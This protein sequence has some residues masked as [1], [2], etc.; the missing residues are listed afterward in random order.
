[1]KS[2]LKIL[3]SGLCRVL[4][5][6]LYLQTRFFGLFLKTDQPFQISS[7]TVSL[8]PGFIGNYLRKEFYR[9]T[10]RSCAPDICVEF[11]TVL[12]QSGIELG[13]RVY[14]GV[15][16]SIGDCII[17]DDVLLGSN[18]DIISGKHQHCFDRLDIPIREQGGHFERIRIGRD[19]WIG[20]SSVVMANIGEQS[21]VAAGSVVTKDIPPRSIVAGNPARI[22]GKRGQS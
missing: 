10:L 1:M 7:H 21:I 6:P 12:H 16:C 2:F 13:H 14:I 22:I 11:A 19:S 3:F 17:E 9:M 5:F 4:I 18:V 8:F 15:N 20:N